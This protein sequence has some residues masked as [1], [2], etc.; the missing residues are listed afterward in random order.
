MTGLSTFISDQS[1]HV[2][3][4]LLFHLRVDHLVLVDLAPCQCRQYQ[5]QRYNHNDRSSL[6]QLRRS[7]LAYD[8][9]HVRLPVNFCIAEHVR[10]VDYPMARILGWNAAHDSMGYPRH[11][12]FGPGSTTLERFR[13]V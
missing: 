1:K 2:L 9:H 8:P 6:S 3:T 13:L 7:R 10:L 5:R 4:L 12:P 11:G